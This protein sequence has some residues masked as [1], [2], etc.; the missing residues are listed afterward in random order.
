MEEEDEEDEEDEDEDGD[1]DS[2]EDMEDAVR[3]A[4]FLHFVPSFHASLF[5]R[6]SFRPCS[7]FFPIPRMMLKHVPKHVG[8]RGLPGN[9]PV[10]HHA[11]THPR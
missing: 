7:I 11:Q 1:E 2:D 8:G 4:S 3:V 9:Q 6:H 5:P 10:V